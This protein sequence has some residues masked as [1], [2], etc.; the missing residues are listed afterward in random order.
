MSRIVRVISEDETAEYLRVNAHGFAF[1]PD[2]TSPTGL[3]GDS[4]RRFALFDDGQMVGVGRNFSM[5]LTMPGG[6][7]VG[8]GGVSWIA[9]HPLH[10]RRGVMAALIEALVADSDHRGEFASILT[11]SEGSIYWGRGYGPATWGMAGDIDVASRP[12]LFPGPAP[13]GSMRLESTALADLAALV[14][15]LIPIFDRALDQPGMV[16]RP[17]HWW[18]PYVHGIT[19]GP[20]YS[21]C[22]IHTNA[23]GVDDGYVIYR[24]AGE[25]S[26][27]LVPDK[28]LEIE[29]F[30]AVSAEAQRSLWRHLLERDLVRT[31]RAERLAA[32]DPIRLMLRD[33]RA[34]QTRGV[35]DR[36]WIRPINTYALLSARTYGVGEPVVIGVD[37]EVFRVSNDGVERVDHAAD[38]TMGRAA[39][40]AALLGGTDIGALVHSGRVLEHRDGA[41]RDGSV[42]F[43]CT[44]DPVMLTNF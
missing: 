4:D 8:A 28:V 15:S 2:P 21:T 6:T 33:G 22:A 40:G 36:L 12:S 25:W 32:S 39:L 3:D 35:F 34:F 9:V 37:G 41:G 31:I 24:A 20:H 44:P 27:D 16:S 11:A 17:A 43:R 29:D 1:R 23:A 38:L 42:L 26:R 5:T 13:T 30:I 10:R 14:A 19:A 7:S 18:G